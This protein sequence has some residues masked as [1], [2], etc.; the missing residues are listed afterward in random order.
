MVPEHK[1]ETPYRTRQVTLPQ[2]G[3]SGSAIKAHVV[4]AAKEVLD[5]VREAEAALQQ[6][7]DLVTRSADS[8]RPP[9]KAPSPRLVRP[10]RETSEAR[11]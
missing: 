7:H 1:I 4:Q 3:Y 2:R 9:P 10:A 8:H 6:L 5:A 11:Q